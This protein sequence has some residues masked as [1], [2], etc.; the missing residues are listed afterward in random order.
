MTSQGDSLES[1]QQE[2]NNCTVQM[3]LPKLQLPI[4][5]GDILQWQEFWDIY[6]SAVHEQ[7]IPNITKF[8]YLKGSLRSSAATAICGISVTN[9]NYPIAIHILQEKFGKREAIVEALYSQLQHLPISM[10]RFSEI[11]NTYEVI[12]RIL[13]QLEA[14]GEK[15]GQQRIL[16]QQIPSKFPTNVIVKLEESKTL[17]DNW[18]IE[19][20]RASLKQYIA[21]ILM[22]NDMR[23][24][25]SHLIQEIEGFILKQGELLQNPQILQKPQFLQKH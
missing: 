13:R 4:F 14:Q 25:L 8:S 17:Q 19:L 6:T 1:H 12:E 21:I 20:L 7:D 24:I 18:I 23:P 3:K 15:I 11:K 2:Q 9:S 5:E 10:N 22:L 16:I